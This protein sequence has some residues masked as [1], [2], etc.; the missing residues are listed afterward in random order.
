MRRRL[1]SGLRRRVVYIYV[2]MKMTGELIQKMKDT[3]TLILTRGQFF[4]H[5]SIIPFLLI[6]PI[7][8]VVYLFQYYVTH[9]YHGR[10]IGEMVTWTLWPLIIA[11]AF[12]FIQ[13]RRLKFKI[14]DIAVNTENFIS[15]SKQTEKELGWKIVEQK[16][17]LIIAKSG[18]SWRSWGEHVTIIK[19]KDRILFNSICDPDNRPSVTSWGMNKKNLKTFEQY[20]RQQ[21]AITNIDDSKD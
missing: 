17:N 11:I 13:K 15:A 5:Y 8:T 2:T 18:F 16:S 7:M 9:T 1:F 12:Y 10:P 20:L 6:A 21:A 14:I 4:W 3:E 19:E